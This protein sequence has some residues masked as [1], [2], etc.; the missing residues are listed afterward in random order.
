MALAGVAQWIECRPANQ[1]VTGPIP[2]RTRAWVVGQVPSWGCVRGNWQ[3]YSHYVSLPLF[4]P[5]FSSKSKQILKNENGILATDIGEIKKMILIN[6]RA[7]R[8]GMIF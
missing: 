4:L 1:K 5:P 3:M 2:V 8:K 7:W 6:L